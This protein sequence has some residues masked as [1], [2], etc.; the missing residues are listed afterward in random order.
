VSWLVTAAAVAYALAMRA[1]LGI[2]RKRVARLKRELAAMRYDLA[3]ATDKNA[4][5]L[6]KENA[7]NARAN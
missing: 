7:Q 2:N 5:F 6:R 3:Y 4:Q 1:L